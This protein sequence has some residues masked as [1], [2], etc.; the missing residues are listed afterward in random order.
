MQNFRKLGIK[1]IYIKVLQDS[2]ISEP[3]PI[4]EESL[5]VALAG[6]DLIAGSATGSGKTL[7][8]V[9]DIL[10]TITKNAGIQALILT[11]TRE[12]AE[13][14]SH[15]FKKFSK[16]APVNVVTIYGGVALG[17]QMRDLTRADLVVGTPGR[18][19][20]HMKRRTINLTQ[21]KI[22]VLDEADR[23]FDMGFKYDVEQI[24]RT[25]PQQRQTLCFSATMSPDVTAFSHRYMHHPTEVL[26]ECS[27]D[28]RKL[29]QIYYDIHDRL[30]FSL[31]VHLLQQEHPGIVIVFCNS[32]RSVEFVS[33][34]LK[35]NK[36]S[37]HAIHGGF[38]QAKRNSIMEDVHSHHVSVLVCTDVAARGLDIKGVSHVYNYDIPLDSKQ[39]IHRIGRTARAGKEGRAIN[40]LSS[41]DHDNFQRVLHDNELSI[42]REELPMLK[43]ITLSQ[44]HH[45]APQR[46]SHFGRRNFSRPGFSRRR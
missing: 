30:K 7:V 10:Q 29:T 28:P 14:V 18:I 43:P 46:R 33:K 16:Y 42:P 31:L 15:V 41:R 4:Q 21:V 25:C 36:I 38:S 22:L 35:H 6:K 9:I 32:R 17:P 1:D 34:N 26:V 24:V 12:L 2:Q 8:F 11:P 23:M 27:V 5:P 3:T 19:L 40:L 37:A 39:Y 44:S 45:D 20:D 13:Q